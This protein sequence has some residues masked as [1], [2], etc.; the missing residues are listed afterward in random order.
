MQ[1][2]WRGDSEHWLEGSKGE[3]QVDG[4][5]SV[6]VLSGQMAGLFEEQQERQSV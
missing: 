5:A 2:D 1:P 6:K 4:S 3:V